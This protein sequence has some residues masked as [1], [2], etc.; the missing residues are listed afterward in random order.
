MLLK[1]YFL[2]Y[3]S[4]SN[5][6]LFHTIMNHDSG[7]VWLPNFVNQF[8]S[9]MG[10][11]YMDNNSYIYQQQRS[12]TMAAASREF[13]IPWIVQRDGVRKKSRC[14]HENI[15][16]EELRENVSLKLLPLSFSPICRSARR[17]RP[18]PRKGGSSSPGAEGTRQPFITCIQI[19]VSCGRYFSFFPDVQTRLSHY[20]VAGNEIQTGEVRGPVQDR[21]DGLETLHLLLGSDQESL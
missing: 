1:S 14:S 5:N 21:Q 17:L 18:L 20:R 8:S 2:V 19:L 6:Q 3:V 7:F 13:L 15:H 16:C 10:I 12:T 9:P 11:H 4:Q